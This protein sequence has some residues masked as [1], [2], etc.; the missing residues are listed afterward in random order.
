MIFAF[1]A[2]TFA[3]VFKRSHAQFRQLFKR[4]AYIHW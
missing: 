4:R 3:E 2:D 1:L